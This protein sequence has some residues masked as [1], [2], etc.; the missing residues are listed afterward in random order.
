MSA[1][2]A[3]KVFDPMDN[4]M[5]RGKSSSTQPAGS[6]A[7]EPAK[8]KRTSPYRPTKPGEQTL[9]ETAAAMGTFRTLGRAIRAAG[10]VDMLSGKGPF[11]VFAPT[12]DAF[13]KMPQPDLDALL[14]DRT[15]LARLLSSHIVQD[16][17]AAP[18][19]GSPQSAMSMTGEALTIVVEP[20]GA[21]GRGFRVNDSAIVKTE[22]LA[23]NGVIHA[24][25][26]VMMPR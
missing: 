8:A 13:A 17:V 26:T 19:V 10:L 3:D 24:I 20:R 18:R 2:K 16:T 14:G 5:R 12:D 25:D 1:M 7:A 4:G 9:V 11:T 15:R 6:N 21:R 23:S 22:I